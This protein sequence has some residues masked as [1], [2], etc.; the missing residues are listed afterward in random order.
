MTFS[1]KFILS[2]FLSAAVFAEN[3][4][5]IG[6]FDFNNNGK[7]E[8]LKINGLVAPLEFVELDDNGNHKTLWIYSPENG[9]AIVDAKFADLDNDKALELIVIQKSDSLNNWLKIFE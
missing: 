3:L 8:M 6:T 2:F 9:G 5:V 7:S 4:H 1:Q